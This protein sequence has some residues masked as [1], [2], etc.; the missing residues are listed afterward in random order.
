MGRDVGQ[1]E[2]DRFFTLRVSGDVL[3][4]VGLDVCG[5]T[6]GSGGEVD[7]D[8][9]LELITEDLEYGA[10]GEFGRSGGSDDGL[11]DDPEQGQTVLNAFAETLGP[12]GRGLVEKA[13]PCGCEGDVSQV[14]R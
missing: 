11:G 4:Q 3:V 1:H 5:G 12:P 6:A 8:I 14:L 13:V 2:V 7:E 10:C 9:V